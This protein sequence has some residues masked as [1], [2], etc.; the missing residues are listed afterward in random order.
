MLDSGDNSL[1]FCQGVVDG[2]SVWTSGEEAA[3]ILSELRGL[4]IEDICVQSSV[5]LQHLPYTL[6]PET[7]LPEGLSTRLAFAVEKVKEMAKV[8]LC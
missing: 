4:G 5:S 8:R 6:E 1:L 7:K 3:Q 2:R